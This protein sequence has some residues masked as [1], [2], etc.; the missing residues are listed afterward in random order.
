ML[1]CW[2]AIA[3]RAGL[4]LV[5]LAAVLPALM[6]FSGYGRSARVPFGRL[7]CALAPVLGVVGLAGAFPAVA[8]QAS[9]SPERAL[10]GALGYWWLILAGPLLSSHLW[11]AAPAGT[12]ATHA[13]E[14]SVSGAATHVIGP[15]LS[16]GVLLGALLWAVAA[17]VLPWIVRGREPLLDAIAAGLWALA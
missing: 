11:L 5:L 2:E 10:R 12:H 3:G 7:W 16:A 1:C 17:M 13:W 6:L 14:E 4:S 8:G 9:S 15:A